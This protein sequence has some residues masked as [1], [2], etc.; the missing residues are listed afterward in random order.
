MPERD[1]QSAL[2]ARRQAARSQDSGYFDS[3]LDQSDNNSE[4]ALPQKE[5]VSP[6]AI[7][8]EQI[9]RELDATPTQIQTTLRI[10]AGVK[11]EIEAFL[12]EESSNLSTF[13]E[14][15]W[16]VLKDCEETLMAV[17]ELANK[18]AEKRRAD[19]NR[20]KILTELLKAVSE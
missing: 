13:S 4:T 7:S 8:P 1:I 15:A 19:G 5:T 6:S 12:R 10:D 17:V 18:K 2:K 16:E 14:A 9:R 20:R 3:A 11:E